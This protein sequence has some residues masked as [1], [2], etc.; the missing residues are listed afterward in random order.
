MLYYA[1]IHSHLNYCLNIYGCANTTTLNKL[2]LK[3]KEAIRVISNAGYRDHTSPL[4]RTLNV[5]PLD[6]LI[7]FAALK[8]MHSFNFNTLPITFAETWILNRV[9]NPERNLRNADDLYIPA[10]K[11]ATLK[12]LP[13]FHFPKIWNEYD[14]HNKFNPVPHLFVK[15]LKS[16]L[17]STLT[18]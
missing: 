11:F 12:R 9:R 3:Q 1:M 5:L 15:H 14:N 2:R 16:A 13:L 17:I 10:H 8:F 6:Q 4:F 18:D 7:Q